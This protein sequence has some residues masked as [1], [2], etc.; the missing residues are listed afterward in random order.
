MTMPLQ[1]ANRIARPADGRSSPFARPGRREQSSSAAHESVDVALDLLEHR[2]LS[3]MELRILFA[4]RGRERSESELALSFDRGATEV[5]RSAGALYARGF[6]H[7][8]YLHAQNDSSFSL[9]PAGKMAVRPLLN[10]VAGGL[11]GVEVD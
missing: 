10:A 3:P 2:R 7:W 4:L 9:T 1:H 11:A 8:R 5:R 6:L